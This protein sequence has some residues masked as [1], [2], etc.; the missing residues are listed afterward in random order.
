MKTFKNLKAF[1]QR[2]RKGIDWGDWIKVGSRIYK[3][4]EFGEGCSND[5]MLFQNKTTKHMIQVEYHC[6]SKT[7]EYKFLSLFDYPNDYLYRY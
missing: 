2:L 6:P 4:V 7:K 1:E 3:M 5:Y